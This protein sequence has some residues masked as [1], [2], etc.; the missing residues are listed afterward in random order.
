MGLYPCINIRYMFFAKIL[1]KSR[2]CTFANYIFAKFKLLYSFI[3][4]L[5]FKT[6]FTVNSP[7]IQGRF[8]RLRYSTNICLIQICVDSCVTYVK[9]FI[10]D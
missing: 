1:P 6:F 7:I 4:A 8:Y 5:I 9:R 2:L 10:Y 3:Y